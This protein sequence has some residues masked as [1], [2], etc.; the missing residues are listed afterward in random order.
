MYWDYIEPIIIKKSVI[1]Q[2]EQG[3]RFKSEFGMVD[4][5]VK[6]DIFIQKF[7]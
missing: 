3:S 6:L 4:S 2:D 7:L 1:L 5:L